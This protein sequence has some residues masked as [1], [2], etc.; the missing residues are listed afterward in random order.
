MP[1]Y[2]KTVIY[3]LCC[4]DASIEDIYIGSTCNF[5]QRKYAHKHNCDNQNHYKYKFKVYEFIRDHGGWNNW[6]MVL[7][8]QEAVENKL[9]KE[10]VERKFI[11]ELKPSLNSCIPT[12]TRKEWESDNK[13]VLQQKQKQYYLHNKEYMDQRSKKL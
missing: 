8:H 9:Q 10:R 4:N 6:S 3:K 11:D 5:A 13:E 1:D 7:V 12:R 2:S